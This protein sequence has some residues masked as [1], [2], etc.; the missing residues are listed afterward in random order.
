LR[1][2]GIAESQR[3]QRLGRV[4][5]E[6]GAG[7][8]LRL[9]AERRLAGATRGADEL[10]L[11]RA[12]LGLAQRPPAQ[13]RL[14]RGQRDLQRVIL[15]AS[16]VLL[17][18]RLERGRREPG[19]RGGEGSPWI[20]GLR[21]P[22]DEGVERVAVLVGE[23]V[24][25]EPRARVE[26]PGG[27]EASQVHLWTGSEQRGEVE[28]TAGPGQGGGPF[29]CQAQRRPLRREL[30]RL[31]IH[32]EPLGKPERR[33]QQI[34][35]RDG[36]R[37]LML[38][39]GYLADVLPRAGEDHQLP[40]GVLGGQ[41]HRAARQIC[42]ER[43]VVLQQDHLHFA[44]Q[45]RLGAPGALAQRLPHALQLAGRV[46]RGGF[47]GG[48]A[49][50]EVLAL[51]LEPERLAVGAPGAMRAGETRAGE[52]D[53]DGREPAHPRTFRE[54]ARQVKLCRDISGYA[55]RSRE[56]SMDTATTLV[57]LSGL[58]VIVPVVVWSFF[59]GRS[60]AVKTRIEMG[61]AAAQLGLSLRI[62]PPYSIS[63]RPGTQWMMT[64]SIAGRE[65]QVMRFASGESHVRIEI[66]S[67]ISS[68]VSFELMTND[69]R[70]QFGMDERDDLPPSISLQRKTGRGQLLVGDGALDGLVAARGPE[71]S[72]RALLDRDARNALRSLINGLQWEQASD[73]AGIVRQWGEIKDGN[74]C[75]ELVGSAACST[76]GEVVQRVRELLDLA[77]RFKSRP[78]ARALCE[79]AISDPQARVRLFNLMTLVGLDR[80]SEESKR[81]VEGALKDDD[82]ELR[83]FAAT[84]ER[85]ERALAVLQE[86]AAGADTPPH[87]RC[88]AVCRLVD[89]Y[90]E[91]EVAEVLAA[92]EPALLALLLEHDSQHVCLAAAGA[93]GKM[94][95]VRAVEP[96]LLSAQRPHAH[97]TLKDAARDS[98]RRIQA[99]LVDAGAGRLSVTAPAQEAGALSIAD[100]AGVLSIAPRAKE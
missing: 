73:A 30:H 80:E 91:P 79:N 89:E 71:D 25:E 87:L 14:L 26:A 72:V 100:G 48:R 47:V 99:R 55:Q 86:L 46:A 60:R 95:S 2:R 52:H 8:D 34:L 51:H 41:A 96:L 92:S 18:F 20:L 31:E 5:R 81:A 97:A 67:A 15:S 3:R 27:G 76:A 84:L 83:F 57:L 94:G 93:L 29:V 77:A 38:E 49:Q 4:E 75:L 35:V 90:P 61:S 58:A 36:V 85:G 22:G 40:E 68:V 88:A 82:P 33:A 19:E 23:Q 12:H 1:A 98:V 66:E 43:V 59:A 24:R 74:I 10:R 56:G 28:R 7:L 39:Y 50:H 78:R 65:V 70:S 63:R 6:R 64:G 42:S 54:R 9:G 53:G 69:E 45:L 44:G 17:G 13:L 37:Q 62:T 21:Q 16:Q 32:R 11:G